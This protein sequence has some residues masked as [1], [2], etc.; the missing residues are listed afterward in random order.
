MKFEAY[1]DDETSVAVEHDDIEE[2]MTA[3]SSAPESDW[4]EIVERV[5][6]RIADRQDSSSARHKV[7]GSLAATLRGMLPAP[8]AKFIERIKICSGCDQATIM[9]S[10]HGEGKAPIAI[11]CTVCGCLMNAKA[12]LAGGRCPLGKFE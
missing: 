3:T 12:R 10:T 11:M 6:M 9:K 7:F 8:K 5:A 2:L 1:V 4:G